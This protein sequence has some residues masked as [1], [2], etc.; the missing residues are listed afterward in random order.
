MSEDGTKIAVAFSLSTESGASGDSSPVAI[1]V[2]GV[3]MDDSRLGV[4]LV[5]VLSQKSA[6]PLLKLFEIDENVGAL[7][8]QQIENGDSTEV[9]AIYATPS[10][11]VKTTKPLALP[12]PRQTN[13][14]ADVR[15]G[16]VHFAWFRYPE[17]NESFCDSLG[18]ASQPGRFGETHRT[19]FGE[20]QTAPGYI[21]ETREFKFSQYADELVEA[22]SR[23]YAIN[24]SAGYFGLL[25]G[26][27]LSSED[28]MRSVYATKQMELS[29]FCLFEI[30]APAIPQEN[31]IDFFPVAPAR[32]REGFVPSISNLIS[33]E[34]SNRVFWAADYL[35]A[36]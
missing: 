14:A 34:T 28:F 33:V 3:K 6:W 32:L 1:V 11:Q 16:S 12:V 17:E 25:S 10:G 8:C 31:L 5:P 24:A 27:A 30:L 36:R 20:T 22:G 13:L 18:K 35:A 21:V 7:L 15:G 19:L 4:K 9:S 23:P 26:S 2:A 29:G